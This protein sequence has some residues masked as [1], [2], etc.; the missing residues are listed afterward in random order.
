MTILRDP[1]ASLCWAFF[2]L[3]AMPGVAATG[4]PDSKETSPQT[5]D[6]VDFTGS[7][8]LNEELSDDP[9][10]KMRQAMGRS[11]GGRGGGGGGGRGSSGG[12]GGGGGRGGG[13]ISGSGG[14][15]G[16]GGGGGRGGRGGRGGTNGDS[17]GEGGFASQL[18]RLR[19]LDVIH[20]EPEL[21]TRDASGR[22]ASIFTD[23]QTFEHTTP[24]GHA[25]ATAVWQRNGRLMIETKFDEDRLQTETWELVAAGQRLYVTTEMGGGE[26]RPKVKIRRVY[27]LAQAAL[28][29][30]D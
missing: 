26:R 14:A 20:L 15:G 30:Q 24:R 18:E 29:P 22:E 3:A 21:L 11:R 12:P 9:R 27:D 25:E 5:S 23:G 2:A 17:T 19:T 6:Q 13:G 28:P 1:L 7:W 16:G 10:E 4:G 8:E